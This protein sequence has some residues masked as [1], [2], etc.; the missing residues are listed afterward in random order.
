M[1]E[2]RRIAQRLVEM[3]GDRAEAEAGATTGVS[4]LTRFAN[5]FI[6]Q[7]VGEEELGVRLRVAADGRVAAGAGN[8]IDDE[9]LSRLV[10]DTLTAASFQPV[11][12]DW[13]GLAPIADVPDVDHHDA[14]TAAASPAD[15]AGVVAGC[16][17]SGALTPTRTDA[18][19]RMVTVTTDLVA[20][21]LGFRL[22][23]ERARDQAT[24]NAAADKLY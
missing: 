5:S 21:R 11:D 24:K 1:S 16:H 12:P 23:L 14:A 9:G 3:V 6:H 19:F 20:A 7:N 10:E 2:P 15:R 17:A 18:G 4:A 22:E 13:P 8:R